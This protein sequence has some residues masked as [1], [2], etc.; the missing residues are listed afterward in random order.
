LSAKILVD[1]HTLLWWWDGDRS[2]SRTAI[3]WLENPDVEI[4]VSAA[5]AWEIATKVR[6]GKL[7]GHV[8]SVAEFHDRLRLNAAFE[9]P[10][11]ATHALRA[12]SYEASHRDPF[13]RL[14]A[15]QSELDGLPLLTADPVFRHFPCRVLW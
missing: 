10:V 15:A 8:R 4:F 2:L 11:S 3:E 9:L 5:S 7:P 1:T 14:L 6:I 13:D 12:G